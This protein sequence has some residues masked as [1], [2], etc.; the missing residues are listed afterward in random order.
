MI[1]QAGLMA[2]PEVD[3]PVVHRWLDWA[4]PSSVERIRGQL[5][6][7]G[8]PIIGL[9]GAL[10]ADGKLSA[11]LGGVRNSGVTL[12]Y[13]VG[14]DRIDVTTGRYGLGGTGNLVQL[15]L[16]AAVRPRV[17][18]PFTVSVDERLII[19]TV[20][21]GRAQFRVVQAS[22][23]HW[24]AAG[25]WKKRHLRLQGSPGTSPESLVLTEVLLP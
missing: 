25:G 15:V 16:E 11:T 14:D 13:V 4:M 1:L 10:A 2:S 19:V 17:Y 5:Q 18:L 8:N 12:A 9:A 22:T 3:K 24:V 20:S 7:F 23:G 21:D 6:E